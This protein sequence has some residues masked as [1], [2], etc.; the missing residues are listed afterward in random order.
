[1]SSLKLTQGCWIIQTRK[2][3]CPEF[4]VYQHNGRPSYFHYLFQYPQTLHGGV[5]LHTPQVSL[6]YAPKS[7]RARHRVHTNWTLMYNHSPILCPRNASCPEIYSFLLVSLTSPHSFHASCLILKPAF[8]PWP[9]LP[10]LFGGGS[11]IRYQSN[12]AA[13]T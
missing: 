9:Y 3:H 13:S 11:F 12:D 4:S 7:R 8:T 5:L 1:M 10:L 6:G 2:S